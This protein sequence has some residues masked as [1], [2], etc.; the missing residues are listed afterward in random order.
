M[1]ID[2]SGKVALVTGGSR[3]LGREM[4][5]AFARHG[6]DVVIAS[7]RIETCEE[8]AD[9]VQRETGRRALPVACHVGRWDDLERLTD[10]AYDEFGHVDVLVNNAGMAPV[11][12]SLVEASEDLF[13]KVVAVN[14][15]G[16]FRL[17]ALVGAR[18]VAGDGGSM[19]NISSIAAQR[20]QV[21]DIPYAA[22]KAGLNTMTLGLATALGP[23]VR[24]NC[25]MVGPFLTDISKAWDVENFKAFA[26]RRY[27]LGRLGEPHEIVGTALYLASDLSSFTTGTVLTVDGGVSVSSPFPTE[28]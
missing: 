18:M 19:I 20:P 26:E 15:K 27:P 28:G 1:D 9:E 14:L 22:A 3:G 23:K 21:H 24:V 2:L 11:Y 5:L 8:V 17:S 4:V 6:A 7:R 13:D 25:V 16:P 12:P 10:A